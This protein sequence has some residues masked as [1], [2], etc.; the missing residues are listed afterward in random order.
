MKA[1]IVGGKIPDNSG[2]EITPV[3]MN[4][5]PLINAAAADVERTR[6]ALTP[7]G[8]QKQSR[9]LIGAPFTG[10]GVALTNGNTKSFSTRAHTA[11]GGEPPA[12]KRGRRFS[13]GEIHQ[14]TLA[15]QGGDQISRHT[16]REK[17]SL[18]ASCRFHASAFFV[19][20]NRVV[21]HDFV[22]ISRDGSI[23]EVV[24]RLCGRV[25]E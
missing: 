4:F 24:R 21:K 12:L 19:L 15:F 16:S 17:M 22:D 7:G 25:G 20:E 14:L 2:K 5:R 6:C 10:G 8:G 9:R 3:H 1:Y 23:A 11:P 18:P 13:P